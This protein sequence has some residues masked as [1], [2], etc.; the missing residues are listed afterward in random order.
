MILHFLHT[1]L[2]LRAIWLCWPFL[3]E[4][5]VSG[6]GAEA[7]RVAE[8]AGAAEEEAGVQETGDPAHGRVLMSPGQEFCLSGTMFYMQR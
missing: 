2:F 8:E 4:G 6:A 1:A 5:T 7:A 3:H